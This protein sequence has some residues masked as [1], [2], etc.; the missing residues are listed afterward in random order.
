MATKNILLIEDNPNDEVLTKRALSKGLVKNAITVLHDGKEALD[1]FFPPDGVEEPLPQ[2]VL[3][4]LKL[5][6]IDGLEVLKQIRG[7]ERTKNIPVVILT[8]SREEKDL[9]TGYSEGANSYIVKPV[10]ME[11]FIVAI[12]NLGLYWLVLNETPPQ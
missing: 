8:S 5:P 1:Y 6:K 11:Q 7:H 2:V 10:D 12:Q 3:L 4:D 9:F